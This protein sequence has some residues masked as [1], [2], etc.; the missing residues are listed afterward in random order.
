MGSL[1]WHVLQ[2]E[3]QF[4]RKQPLIYVVS[5]L[6]FLLAFAGTA[7]ENVSIG[8]SAGNMNLNAPF[9]IMQ[10]M[11]VFSVI[12]M[13]AAVAFAAN[14]ILRD[15]E[16]RTAEFFYT[17]QVDRFSYLMGRFTAAFIFTYITMVAATLGVL[18]GEMMPWLDQERIA[19]TSWSAYFFVHWVILIPNCFLLASTFF[20]CSDDDTEHVRRV[21]RR[22]PNDQP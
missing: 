14:P 5:T 20:L 12:G 7:S 22:R 16:H 3:L 17:T 11:A 18:V 9:M 1:Y 6:F 2:F 4:H 21:A 10:T 19:D 8:G 15:F 13:F